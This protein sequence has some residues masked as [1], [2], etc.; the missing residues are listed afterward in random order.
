MDIGHFS[1]LIGVLVWVTE[2]FY[3][4]IVEVLCDGFQTQCDVSYLNIN[5]EILMFAFSD[6]IFFGTYMYFDVYKT[7]QALFNFKIKLAEGI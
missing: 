7:K 6:I 4:E 5:F 1:V 2:H 3:Y